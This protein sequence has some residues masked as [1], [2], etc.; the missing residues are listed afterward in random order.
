M[1]DF[2]WGDVNEIDSNSMTNENGLLGNIMSD[3]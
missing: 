3:D 2:D 1:L